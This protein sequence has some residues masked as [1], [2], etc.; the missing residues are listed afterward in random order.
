V[1][2]RRL[3]DRGDHR[4]L[5]GTHAGYGAVVGVSDIRSLSRHDDPLPWLEG[6]DARL[7]HDFVPFHVGVIDV[8]SERHFL[9]LH[10]IEEVAN[11]VRGVFGEAAL[12]DSTSWTEQGQ[13]RLV[14]VEARYSS[15]DD[16]AVM[17]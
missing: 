13:D 4:E 12:P 15:R 6:I 5:G 2:V 1:L 7:Q 16:L 9:A 17:S 10:V 8:A 14:R 11:E 3:I